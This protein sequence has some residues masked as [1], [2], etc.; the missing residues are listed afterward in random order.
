M[1]RDQARE[2]VRNSRA[3]VIP[4]PFIHAEFER[5]P[6]SERSRQID[7]IARKR[8][9]KSCPDSRQ[10]L[11]SGG[12]KAA[13]WQVY[14]AGSREPDYLLMLPTGTRA[15][16]LMLIYCATTAQGGRACTLG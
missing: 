2:I 5:M 4:S 10:Q 15:E 16:G 13:S 1:S 9:N 8:W 11:S 7:M 6:R 14:C 12:A 3:R